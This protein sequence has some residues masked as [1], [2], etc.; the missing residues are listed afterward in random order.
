MPSRPAA[1]ARPADPVRLAAVRAYVAF[2]AGGTFRPNAPGALRETQQRRLYTNLLRGMVRH[3]RRLEAEAARLA[4]RPAQRL[5]AAVMGALVL[6]LYQLFELRQ[7]EHAAVFETVALLGALGQSRAKG[8][9]NAVLRGALREW[10]SGSLRGET[11]VPLAE[12]TSHPDWLVERWVRRYGAETAGRIC[13]AN[14]RFDSSGVRVNQARIGR[15][16]LLE[17]LAREGVDAA[18]HPSLPGALLVPRLGALLDSAAF[19]EGLC[20]VQ[21]AGSQALI[22]W[23]APLL[24]GWVLDACCAPGGK[25]THLAELEQCRALARGTGGAAGTLRL[26][27]LDLSA[28]R[29]TRVRENFQR[30]RLKAPPL[31]AGD[32]RRL[33]FRAGAPDSGWNTILLDAPCSATGMIRKYPELKWLRHAADLP[34]LCGLQRALLDAAAPVLAPQGRIVYVTCSLEPEENEEQVEAFLARTLGFRRRSFRDLPPPQDLGDAAGWIGDAGDLCVLPDADRMGLF[35]AILEPAPR[36]SEGSG[37]PPG[38]RS[39][40]ATEMALE[41]VDS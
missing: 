3:S 20:Y 14:N 17:R 21:D 39:G 30:L 40:G 13:E 37:D 34:R 8:L 12:R 23:I 22:C 1:H 35:A 18:A 28:K 26:V 6:G 25:L 19:A 15:D 41:G 16:G 2:R 10:A 36:A 24:R 5:S 29:L 31:V 9:V 33:P 38:Q 7:A 32:G 11:A 4:R 27:G